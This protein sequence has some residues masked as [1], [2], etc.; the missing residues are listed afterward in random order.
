MPT[1]AEPPVMPAEGE[2]RFVIRNLG[3]DG[4]QTLLNLLD[5]HNIRLTYDRG[6]V[7]LMSPL[8]T[9]EYPTKRLACIIEGIGSRFFLPPMLHVRPR[10]D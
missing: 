5:E 2:R 9:Y 3:W 10:I 1:V 6:D 4:D 8:Y 7:E